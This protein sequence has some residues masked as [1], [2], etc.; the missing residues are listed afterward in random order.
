MADVDDEVMAGEEEEYVGEEEF[1]DYEDAEGGD[2]AAEDG[3]EVPAEEED[4]DAE[5]EEEWND[6]EAEE[7]AAVDAVDD[8]APIDDEAEKP[9]PKKTRQERPERPDRTR[10]VERSERDKDK[11]VVRLRQQLRT[12]DKSS[13]FCDALTEAIDKEKIK[14]K[15]AVIE[16]LDISQNLIPVEQWQNIFAALTDQEVHVERFRAFGCPTFN[17]DVADQLA[18]WLADLNE[19]NLPYEMHLSDNAITGAGFQSLSR[20]LENNDAFPGHDPKRPDKGKLPLYLR[21]ECNYI[22]ETVIQ[23]QIDNG[24]YIK[25]KKGGPPNYHDTAKARI[26]CERGFQQKTG[27]PP[28]PEDAPAPKRVSEKGKG[29]SKGKDKDSRGKGK[30][31]TKGSSK[32][33]DSRTK[34]CKGLG[35]PVNVKG[36]SAS[37]VEKG[38]GKSKTSAK[39]DVRG[40]GKSKGKAVREEVRSLS[41]GTK[42]AGKRPA[43]TPVS[44]GSAKGASKGTSKGKD[45]RPVRMALT[46]SRQ[47]DSRKGAARD[48]PGKGASREQD[49]SSGGKSAGK[50]NGHRESGRPPFNAFA[51]KA[52]VKRSGSANL[53]EDRRDV[54][55][56]PLRTER[57]DTG[58]SRTSAAPPEKKPRVSEQLPLNWEKHYSEE[59]KLHYY[60]NKKNGESQWDKPTR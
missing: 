24:V 58:S 53:F 52:P 8:E 44:K 12:S 43:V 25:M 51:D 55:R 22:D 45:A 5:A 29:I 35:R 13:R 36:T 46:S 27:E 37:A 50:A 56:E 11:L 42:G 38:R 9:S 26:L 23:E 40:K 2:A 6:E 15:I 10:Y 18:G 34:A 7:N 32:G 14:G 48:R 4:G 59:Y 33:K 20:A 1:E 28:A 54:R 49:R 57:R 30:S 31:S 39:D 60:W 41:Q 17:D 3:D 16:D 21:L 47:E 19:N